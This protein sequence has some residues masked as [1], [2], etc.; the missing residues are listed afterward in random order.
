VTLSH[1]ATGPSPTVHS[2]LT[3]LLHRA[4][5]R[6]RSVTN[7]QADKHGIQL[8]DHIVLSALHATTGL[9]QIELGKTLGIDK[10]TLMAQLD[11]LERLGL[12]VR[13]QDPRDRRA[14]IPE[15]TAHGEELR[16][17]VSA[18]ALAAEAQ[19]VAGYDAGEV[20]ALRRILFGIIGDS[21]DPGSCL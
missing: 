15:I 8:R 12:V 20:M 16:I 6:M 1:E 17:R 2:E 5:Q 9:T 14:R 18:D 13:R 7:E 3:W 11:R 19:V 10:T 21:E 4:A